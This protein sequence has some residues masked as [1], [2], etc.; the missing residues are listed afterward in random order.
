MKRHITIE[1]LA[2]LDDE[3]RQK[4]WDWWRPVV[5]DLVVTFNANTVP[6]SFNSCVHL[7][8]NGMG[9]CGR[10]PILAIGQ[11]VEFLD[12]HQMHVTISHGE[13]RM[14][15]DLILDSRF[16]GV[17]MPWKYGDG[18]PCFSLRYQREDVVDVLWIAV[19]DVLAVLE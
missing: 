10:F 5:G 19:K 4:L 18:G 15:F 9:S 13:K 1:Q 2:E 8:D 16:S 14:G 17:E 11:M 3:Q 12:D 6:I 7:Y